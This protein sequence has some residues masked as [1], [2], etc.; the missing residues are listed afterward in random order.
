MYFHP[1]ESLQPVTKNCKRLQIQTSMTI[2]IVDVARDVR[3]PQTTSKRPSTVFKT[4]T[5]NTSKKNKLKGGG[6][7]EI[8]DSYL[9]EILFIINF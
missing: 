8:D 7:I 6:N 4:V 9:G 2:R 1:I 5:S 3:R